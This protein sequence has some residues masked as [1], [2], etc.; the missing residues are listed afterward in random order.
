MGSNG[1]T[2]KQLVKGDDDLRQ[3]AVMQQ[4]FNLVN[5]FLKEVASTRKRMLRI[6]TYKVIPLSPCTGILEWVQNTTPIGTW[7]VGNPGDI[8]TH[9]SCAHA[10]YC[11][12]DWSNIKCRLKFK[13]ATHTTRIDIY[14]EICDHFHP[15]FHHFFLENFLDPPEWF[16]KRLNYTRSVASNSMVGYILGLGDRHA[17]N[18]LLDTNSGEIVQIDLGVAFD[19]GKALPIP[20]I[21]PFR[22]TR[23]LVDAMGMTGVEGVFKRC[24]EETMEV[25][26]AQMSQLVTVVEVFIHDPLYRWTLSPVQALRLQREDDENM[27]IVERDNNEMTVLDAERT[28]LRVK[29]KLQG[30]ESGQN[31]T[32]KSQVGQLINSATDPSLLCQMFQGWAPWI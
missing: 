16:Q 1:V 12:N 20:E 14:N 31:L 18:I 6:R 13:E 11:P 30:N 17:Q 24:C 3:D 19:Q 10:R 23:D 9:R 15:V 28:L 32:V 5:T 22:L 8:E 2:Y 21:V 27:M 7:L 29:Q 26:R 4:M 25:L